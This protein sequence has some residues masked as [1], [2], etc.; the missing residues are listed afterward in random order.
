VVRRAVELG[1][2]HIDTALF[3]EN[4]FVNDVLREALRPADEV[5]VVTKVG[6]DPDPG[7]PFPMRPAQHP[8]E[9][10]ASVEDNLR[11]LGLEQM[12]PRSVRVIEAD[13]RA[14]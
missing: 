8:H 10:R 1:V 3:Y 2:G 6:A 9:L 14:E 13:A 7:G 4:G 12:G 5:M 11:S